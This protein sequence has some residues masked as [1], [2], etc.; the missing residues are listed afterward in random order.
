MAA[1]P[2][3]DVGLVLALE[4]KREEKKALQLEGELG[5]PMAQT[6]L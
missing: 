6:W 2:R 1:V 3:P 5:I 4:T